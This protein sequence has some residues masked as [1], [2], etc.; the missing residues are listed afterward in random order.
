MTLNDFFELL[1]AHPT[2]TLGFLILIPAMAFIIGIIADDRSHLNPWKSVYMILLYL[3]C[4][5]GIFSV[6]LLIFTFLFE[7]RSIYDIDLITHVLPPIS[8]VIT[9]FV[10]KKY[11]SLDR[12]PGFGKLT[13]LIM[14]I[15]VILLLFWVLQKTRII[16]FT[17]M[18]IVY[19]LLILL[20]LILVFRFGVKRFME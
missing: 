20:A 10:T 3:I 17:Y 1:N 13:G 7:N 16:M 15:S 19:V 2:Y 11:V 8:M 5:P 6:T 14:M 9:I 4:I 18:P 12:V